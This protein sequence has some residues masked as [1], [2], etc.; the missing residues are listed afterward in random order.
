MGS[1]RLPGKILKE[2]SGKPMLWHVYN[3]VSQSHLVNRVIVA[4]SDQPEDDAVEQF[5]K[6]NFIQYYRGSAENVLSRYYHAAKYFNAEIII[7]ITADCPVIDPI[8]LDNM[9]TE[10]LIQINKINI[11]YLS[12]SLTRTFPR[13]LDIE[14]FTF[15]ALEKTFFEA[16]KKYELEH[17]TPYIYQNPHKFSIMNYA[18]KVDNSHYRWTVDTEEDFELITEIYNRLYSPERFFL[19]NEILELFEKHPEF[20]EIN[21]SIEQKKLE[22]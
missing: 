16:E 22:E 4:T 6:D 18:N 8:I 1:S 13:G 10:F 14:I 19:T 20:F 11:D 12:N 3:R 15:S 17:V 2:L 21:R 9:I 5:C 7:R